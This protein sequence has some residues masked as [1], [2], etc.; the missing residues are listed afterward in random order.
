LTESDLLEKL[1][2]VLGSLSKW[3]VAG[4]MSERNWKVTHIYK[5]DDVGSRR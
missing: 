3:A 5:K 4:G 1:P 2:R